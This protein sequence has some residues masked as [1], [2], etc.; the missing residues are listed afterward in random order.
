MDAGGLWNHEV[1]VKYWNNATFCAGPLPETS[2]QGSSGCRLFFGPIANCD[3]V[4]L[5]VSP[6]SNQSD[7]VERE[8]IPED[9]K[10]DQVRIVG[11]ACDQL[12][13]CLF[14]Q[15]SIHSPVLPIRMAVVEATHF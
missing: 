13:D 15:R 6:N 10:R 1:Q 5:A 4:V 7:D 9:A 12:R 14:L 2:G 11:R 3:S 8:H